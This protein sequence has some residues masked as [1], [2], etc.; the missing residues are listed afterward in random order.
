MD[1]RLGEAELGT[2]HAKKDFLPCSWRYQSVMGQPGRI[3]VNVSR[4]WTYSR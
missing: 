3:I 1:L 2:E 4:T